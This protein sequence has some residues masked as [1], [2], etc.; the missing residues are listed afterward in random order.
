MPE[1][2]KQGLAVGTENYLA[3]NAK[4]DDE[5]QKAS[6]DF[7]NWLYT[8]DKGKTHVVEDLGF[9]APF[10]TFTKEDVPNDPLAKEIAAAMD[11][12]EL[13]NIPWDF[14]YFPSQKFK[15][16]FGQALGQYASGNLEWDEVVKTFVDNWE[17]EKASAK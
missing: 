12:T 7:I 4:A 1:D 15:D 14:Q 13:T 2:S 8:T 10:N 11:N 16:D 3:V 9:I 6:I 5:D 17:A